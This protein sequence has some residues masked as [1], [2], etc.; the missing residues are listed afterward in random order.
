MTGE[1]ACTLLEWDSAFFGRRIAR[2]NGHTLTPA[3]L[4]EVD[5][6]CR[7]ERVEGLYFLASASDDETARLAE[8]G[9]FALVDIRLT[10]ERALHA[11]DMSAGVR[12]ATPQDIPAL[13]VIARRAFT[14]SRFYHDPVI[15]VEQADA[16]YETWI[17][18]S[19]EGFADVVL[20]S[21]DQGG[22]TGFITCR[23]LNAHSGDIG[24]VGVRRDSAGRGLGVALTEAALSWF[25]MQ[26]LQRAQVVTQGR[27]I[28]AQRLYQKCGFRTGEIALW[29]H[30][31][32][33]P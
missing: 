13:Q 19:L 5:A 2:V 11:H 32:G 22:V 23:R 18:R 31:W 25:R 8:R 4:A 27:N 33:T 7:T 9:G 24:L 28:A 26:G 10:L 6:F 3:R 12:T 20:V 15:A 14:D 1:P 17:A 29:Y 30:R 21:E 16:L